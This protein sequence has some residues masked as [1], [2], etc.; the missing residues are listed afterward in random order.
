M[1]SEYIPYL[2]AQTMLQSLLRKGQQQGRSG[3]SSQTVDHSLIFCENS[4]RDNH[5]NISP[6]DRTYV[7]RWCEGE[8]SMLAGARQFFFHTV[9]HKMYARIPI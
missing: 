3:N 1:M 7:H 6:F 5:A 4:M 8:D 9:L 2:T